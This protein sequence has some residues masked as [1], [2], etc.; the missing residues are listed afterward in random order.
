MSDRARP[1]QTIPHRD[2]ENL[3][4]FLLELNGVAIL[5]SDRVRPSQTTP[6]RDDEKLHGLRLEPNGAAILHCNDAQRLFPVSTY[7]LHVRA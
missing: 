1:S 4:Q 6:H 5:K 7:E 3:H 2:D